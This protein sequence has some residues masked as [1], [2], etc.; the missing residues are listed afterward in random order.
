MKGHWAAQSAWLYILLPTSASHSS[1]EEH[2]HPCRSQTIGLVQL[3]HDFGES[4]VGSC[5][6]QMHVYIRYMLMHPEI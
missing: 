5:R 3:D 2:G 6:R 4:F 1:D